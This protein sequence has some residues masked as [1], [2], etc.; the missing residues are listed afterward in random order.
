MSVR[1][2]EGQ[3]REAMRRTDQVTKRAERRMR[4]ADRRGKEADRRAE[5]V[6]RRI[7]VSN[8]EPRPLPDMRED[9]LPSMPRFPSRPSD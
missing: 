5:E 2:Q 4:E 9:S 7:E 3:A 8:I 1:D 6:R